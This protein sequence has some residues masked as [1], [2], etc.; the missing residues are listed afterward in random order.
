VHGPTAR[1]LMTPMKFHDPL[2]NPLYLS[3]FLILVGRTLPGRPLFQKKNV[4]TRSDIVTFLLDNGFLDVGGRGPRL[5]LVLPICLT[6]L[7]LNLV[8]VLF[9]FLS[10]YGYFW[11]PSADP[12][13]ELSIYS[14]KDDLRGAVFSLF[15]SFEITQPPSG[16]LAVF[17]PSVRTAG[18]RSLGHVRDSLWSL[19]FVSDRKRSEGLQVFANYFTKPRTFLFSMAVDVCSSLLRFEEFLGAFDGSLLFVEKTS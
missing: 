8:P 1:K 4:C 2:D 11:N 14:F 18:L 12:K 17:L 6:C 7:R 5:Y 10:V 16:S 19:S 9:F 13:R 3:L 15:L